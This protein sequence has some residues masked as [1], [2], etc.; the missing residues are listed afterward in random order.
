MGEGLGVEVSWDVERLCLQWGR[1]LGLRPEAKTATRARGTMVGGGSGRVN[2]GGAV[3]EIVA[4]LVEH[5]RARLSVADRLWVGMVARR[6]WTRARGGVR[7]MAAVF[8][9]RACAHVGVRGP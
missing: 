3:R 7:G 1:S 6:G 5:G 2:Q 9:R 8:A 4:A